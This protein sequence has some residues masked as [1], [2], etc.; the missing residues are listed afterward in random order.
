MTSGKTSVLTD[1]NTLQV[2]NSTSAITITIPTHASVAYPLGT[3]I[4][5]MRYNT[6][7]ANIAVSSGVTV[8]GVTTTLTVVNRYGVISFVQIEI[9]KW[10]AVGDK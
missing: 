3:A 4:D 5:V 8:N 9:D 2:V 6:G 7:A 10:I 1:A